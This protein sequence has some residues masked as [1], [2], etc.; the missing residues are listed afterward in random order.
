MQQMSQRLERKERTEMLPV[1]PRQEKKKR[2]TPKIFYTSFLI[3]PL[4]M[5]LVMNAC[6][7]QGAVSMWEI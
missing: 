5:I 4:E 6:R 3:V 1:L 7:Y 2:K